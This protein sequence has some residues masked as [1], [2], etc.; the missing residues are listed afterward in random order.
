MV[1]SAPLLREY[2][3]LKGIEGSNPSLSAIGLLANKSLLTESFTLKKSP[4][5]KYLKSGSRNV[6]ATYTPNNTAYLVKF[7]AYSISYQSIRSERLV[8]SFFNGI[9]FWTPR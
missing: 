2:T 6:E 9:H 4:K 1:E 8:S 7:D 5:S 3:P